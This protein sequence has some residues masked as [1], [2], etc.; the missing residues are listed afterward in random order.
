MKR[1]PKCQETKP[2]T[3]FYSDGKS[4][5]CK[6]CTKADVLRWVRENP[7]QFRR[8]QRK[9]ILKRRFGLTEDQ[10][11]LLLEKQGGVCPICGDPISDQNLNV[12]HDHSAGHVR[13]ILCARCNRTIGLLRDDP[14]LLR[15]AAAYLRKPARP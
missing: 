7:E 5:Y 13:G 11:A 4:T 1:C 3:E 14:A 6:P 10:L 12:D 2:L 9:S 8:T 15:R